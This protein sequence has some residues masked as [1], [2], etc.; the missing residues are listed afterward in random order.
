MTRNWPLGNEFTVRLIMESD[1]HVGSG[2]GRPGSV[3]RLIIRD[4]DGL[5]FVPAKT[6]RGIWR[7]ACERVAY[8]LDDG[9]VGDWSR[10]VDCLF[11]SQP[12]LGESDPTGRHAN[13]AEVPLES[14]LT[15][16]PARMLE[17]LR[18]CLRS[19][20]RLLQSLTFV[21]PGVKIDRRSGQAQNDF[22]RFEEMA[23]AGTVLESSCALHLPVDPSLRLAT[24]A[25]LIAGGQLVERLGGKR[26]RGPGRC[27]L[28]VLD[29][30]V[31]KALALL[32]DYQPPAWPMAQAQPQITAAPAGKSPMADP[33]LIVPLTLHLNGPLAVSYRTVGNVVETLDFLPGSYLLPHVTRTLAAL[34]TDPRPAISRGDLCVLPATLEINGQRGQPVPMAL[35]EEKGKQG[36]KEPASCL[37]NRLLEGDQGKPQLKQ[38]RDGYLRRGGSVD[39]P[40]GMHRKVPTTVQTHNTVED[41]CAAADDRSGRGVHIRGDR[42]RRRGATRSIAERTS[43]TAEPGRSAQGNRRRLVATIEGSGCVGP[44]EEGRLWRCRY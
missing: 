4:A 38:V 1:W 29:V 14:A 23:R 36:F 32:A 5:P 42:A 19:D 11:G 43:L 2:T 44:I 13:S 10:L 31:N 26:R 41:S 25:P 33:W 28:E 8:G 3:D 12:A 30:D 18:R 34:G 16:R 15:V 6:L 22:L 37:T 35:F 40:S 17:N 9:Q 21:K 20:P 24:S 27:R 7:D 39:S